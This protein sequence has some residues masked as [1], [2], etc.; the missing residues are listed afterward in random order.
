MMPKDCEKKYVLSDLAL[1]TSVIFQCDF[2]SHGMPYVLATPRANSNLQ[3][4]HNL[5]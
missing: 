4:V 2:I 3:A 1:I 5:E